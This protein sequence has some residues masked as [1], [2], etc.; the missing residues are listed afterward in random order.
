MYLDTPKPRE[1]RGQAHHHGAPPSSAAEG[2]VYLQKEHRRRPKL[3]HGTTGR[4]A[5]TPY[6]IYTRE[7]GIPRP[8]AAGAADGGRGIRRSFEEVVDLRLR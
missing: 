2:D 3:L 1:R 4:K 5:H 7:T 8:P 6:P